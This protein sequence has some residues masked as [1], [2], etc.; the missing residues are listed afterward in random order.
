MSTVTVKLGS[1]I[2]GVGLAEVSMLA[3][4]SVNSKADFLNYLL[5]NS[6]SPCFLESK[7]LANGANT[8]SIPTK[9]CGVL[10]A[11]S[12]DADFAATL[13]GVSGDTG[14]LLAK[15]GLHMLTFDSPPPASFVLTWAGRGKLDVACTADAGTDTFTATAHGLSNGDRIKLRTNSATGSVPGGVIDGTLYYI[16]GAAANTFQISAT[17]G[18]T[19]VDLTSTGT[20]VVFSTVD[21]FKLLWF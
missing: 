15:R 1:G 12:Q 13:K 14:I 6:N 10:I 18:G 7:D 3:N 4:I 5:S 19:A 17:L 2:G 20:S 8:I 21:N 9:S 11:P 16:V